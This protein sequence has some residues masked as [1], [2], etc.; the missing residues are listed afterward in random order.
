VWDFELW[1]EQ[2]KVCADIRRLRDE[3]RAERIR[4]S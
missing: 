2:A 4:H 3:L 1:H